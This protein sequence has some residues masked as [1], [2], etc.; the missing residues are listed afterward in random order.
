[1]TSSSPSSYSQDDFKAHEEFMK[2]FYATCPTS[3]FTMKPRDKDT[4]RL[5]QFSSMV[6]ASSVTMALVYGLSISIVQIGIDVFFLGFY[7]SIGVLMVLA[8]ER[9]RYSVLLRIFLLER[10]LLTEEMIIGN[11]IAVSQ[12]SKEVLMDEFAGKVGRHVDSV[13]VDEDIGLFASM[14]TVSTS[15]ESGGNIIVESEV[16]LLPTYSTSTDHGRKIAKT[17]GDRV[18]NPI[19]KIPAV[20]STL[21]TDILVTFF[22][23]LTKNRNNNSR[24]HPIILSTNQLHITSKPTLK[25]PITS[26]PPET[27]S[28]KPT[29][30]TTFLE[31]IGYKTPYF[32]HLQSFNTWKYTTFLTS[33]KYQLLGLFIDALLGPF[34]D[35]LSYCRGDQVYQPYIICTD[36]VE[37]TVGFY[38]RVFGLAGIPLGTFGLLV[39]LTGAGVGGEGERKYRFEDIVRKVTYVSLFIQFLVFSII[40]YLSNPARDTAWKIFLTSQ[41]KWLNAFFTLSTMDVVWLTKMTDLI[42]VATFVILIRVPAQ[43]GYVLSE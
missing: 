21:K 6:V 8:A 41:V 22:S 3:Y 34:I 40:V 37:H 30:L 43:V 12:F 31:K 19:S 24:I 5:V 13:A 18:E 10:V 2:S 20:L 42:I 7:T 33:T 29:L 15:T 26:S 4:R 38:L 25:T 9:A 14:K 17:V 32:E 39:V 11:L 23:F 27:S 16:Y 35:S 36:S 28:Q 1:M